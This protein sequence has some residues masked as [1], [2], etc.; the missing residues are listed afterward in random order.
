MRRLQSDEKLE[1]QR[2]PTSRPK[3]VTIYMKHT[4]TWQAFPSSSCLKRM[5]TNR[6]IFGKL[7]NYN[8][9]HCHSPKNHLSLLLAQK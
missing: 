9:F 5:E 4:Q 2:C 1:R 6:D 3:F 7:K 8:L